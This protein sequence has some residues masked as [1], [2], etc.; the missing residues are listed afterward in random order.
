MALPRLVPAVLERLPSCECVEWPGARTSR[1]VPKVRINRQ[2]VCADRHIYS[3]VV[4]GPGDFDIE[5][6]CR[7]RFCVNPA[8]MRIAAHRVRVRTQ[9]AHVRAVLSLLP[10]SDCVEWPGQ[11]NELGYGEI[12][13]KAVTHKAHR[14]IYIKLHG[15]PGPLDMDHLCRNPG[16]VNPDHLEPVPHAENVR[17]GAAAMTHC[18]KK[19]HEWTPENTIVRKNGTRLCRACRRDLERARYARNPGRRNR[20]RIKSMQRSAA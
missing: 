20:Q 10:T 18:R 3:L 15:D 12:S 16:C 1:G 9:S 4:G 5:H 2:M 6:T 17:R 8:H 13:S 19:L 14:Y 11:R 7:N